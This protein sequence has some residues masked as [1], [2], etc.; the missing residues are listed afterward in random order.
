MI[1]PGLRNRTVLI[2]GANNPF[3]IGAAAAVAFAR[4]GARLFVH[5]FRTREDLPTPTDGPGESFYRIQ[6]TKSCD[7]LAARLAAIGAEMHAFEADFLNPTAPIELF[8]AAEQALGRIEV[9]V[10]NAAAW[11]SDTFVPAG[12]PAQNP[13]VELWTKTTPFSYQ[14]LTRVMS[15]NAAA[16]A[17]LMKEFASRHRG[18]GGDWGRIVNISTDAAACFPSEVSYG[19]SKLALESLTRSAARELGQFG[20]TVNAIALGPVQTGWITS[21]LERAVVPRIPLGR[22]GTPEDVADAVVFFCSE[23]ARWITGQRV[24]VAG[25]HQM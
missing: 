20:I 13:L 3:G 14:T 7:G 4:L 16:P 5:F 1:D 15:V 17:L 24:F 8:A 9:L 10:N 23:Q 12:A 11:E 2:T 21:E 19:A 6:Q 18:H 25:G 22:L